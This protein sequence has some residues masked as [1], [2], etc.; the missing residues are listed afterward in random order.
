VSIANGPWLRAGNFGQVIDE[1]VRLH[2]DRRAIVTSSVDVSYGQLADRAGRVATLIGN[3]GVRRGDV[4]ALAV[5]NDWR[6]VEC[7]LGVLRAG[8]VALLVNTKLGPEALSYIAGHSETRLVIG[9]PDLESQALALA[10]GAPSGCTV[11]MAGDHDGEPAAVADC[12]HIAPIRTIS[13]SL[14]TRLDQPARR[15]A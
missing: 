13:Q 14:C 4:V 6:F 11:V 15:R 8:A 3:R 10:A 12:L 1:A 5:G 7:L 9:H 2:P